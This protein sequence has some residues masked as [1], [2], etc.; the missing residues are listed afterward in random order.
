MGIGGLIAGAL[1]GAAEGYGKGA[2][3]EMK[4]A[5]EIDLKKQISEMDSEMRLREDEVRRQRDVSGRVDEEKRLQTPEYLA[6]QAKAAAAR[7]DALVAAGV[8]AA[9]ARALVA[10]G[11]AAAQ[12]RKALAPVNVEAATAEFKA[13]APLDVAKA[14]AATTA[15]ITETGALA[16]DAGFLE[17]TAKLS[18]ATKAAEIEQARIRAEAISGRNGGFVKVRSTYTDNQ[19][20]K[21]AVMSDGTT[22]V[23]GKAA[24]YDKTLST[25][26]TNMTKNDP[27]KFGKLSETE[28]RKQA[29][30]RLHGQIVVPS[31]GVDLSKFERDA[32]AD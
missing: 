26:I 24:D 32:A 8:P 18:K 11:E 30:E 9:E 7:F 16:G 29:E 1:G 4:K 12:T 27:F 10:T 3:M 2:E 6:N 22:K 21:L 25:L 23:L 14:T 20:Q 13:N 31:S 19:G 5:S 17:G 28:K 15:K